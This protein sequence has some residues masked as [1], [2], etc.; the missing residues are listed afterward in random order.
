MPW[1]IEL[2]VVSLPATASMMTKKPNSSSESFSPSMS[3]WISVVTMSSVGFLPRSS[4]IGHRVHDQFHR[5]LRG[6]DVGV[7]GVLAAG[8]L[9]GPAEQLVAVVLWNAEQAGD[10]LQRKLAR[11]LLDEVAA[12]LGGRGLGDVLG[13][14]GEFLLQPSDGPWRETAG[15]DLAQPGVV[16]RVHVEHD[17]ALQLDLLTFHLRRPNRDRTV[18]PAGEDVVALGHLFDIGVLG[19]DPVA[20]VLEATRSVGH[21]HPVNR[22]GLTQ[23]GQLLDG[24]PGKVDVG[25]EEVEVGRNDWG[26]P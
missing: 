26:V 5:R 22:L 21:V 23:L 6:I 12:A 25:V 2:R 14:L 24:Q 10:G 3:A 11:H 8:H 19:D 16:R 18:Q 13:T 7:L 20:V 17:A 15:D 9:V 4:A 1:V